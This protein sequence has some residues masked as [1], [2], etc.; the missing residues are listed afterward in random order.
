MDKKNNIGNDV[1]KLTFA[2]VVTMLITL[3]SSMLLSRFRTLEEYGTYSQ[4]LMVISL[5][6]SFMM[7]GLPNCINYF[8]ARAD[9]DEE[10]ASF[11]SVYYTLSSVLSLLVGIV[12]VLMIPIMEI[13]L[14]N[15]LIRI[16]WFFL[17]LY[18][19]TKIITSSVENLLIVYHK[20]STLFYYRILNG[21]ILLLV[22]IIIQLLNGSFYQYMIAFLGVEIIFTLYT[23]FLAKQNCK[24][25]KYSLNK[26]MIKKIF[27][28]SIPIGLSSMLGTLNIEIDKLMITS[29]FTTE[30]LAVYTNASK[31]L[32]VTI[33]ATSITA[34]LMPQVVRLLKNKDKAKAFELWNS[35]TSISFAIISVIAIG[36]FTFA[37][38]VIKI[39]YS[40]KYLAGVSV[41]RIYCMVLLGK[42]TYFGLMLNA[43]GETKC[44]MYSSIGSLILNII[45]NYS[46]YKLFGF[47][48][49]AIAT[50]CATYLMI[51]YQLIFT[52]KKTKTRFK[53]V[54]PWKNSTKYLLIN[55]IMGLCFNIV[56]QTFKQRINDVLLA[57]ICGGIWTLVF[58][59]I[60]YKSLMLNW[61]KLNK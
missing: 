59:V 42:C 34:V 39:L 37:P 40:E 4:L 45:F 38:Q 22:I 8:L 24:L 36:C 43:I 55:I 31:E 7:L 57:L 56:M 17:A 1:V 60:T 26:Q 13:Y 23:Y 9:S 48:G 25:L 41:F 54:F 6:S 12:L 32:P 30:D 18:P 16:F 27:A 49:P 46:G 53:Y 50:M 20:T 14:K 21:S 52:C 10:R 15:P 47:I 11:L 61:I 3:V 28:F 5:A 35:A 19:W 2:K 51:F 33:I 58:T 29:F 44:I